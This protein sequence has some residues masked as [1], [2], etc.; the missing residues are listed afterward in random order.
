VK[1][2]ASWIRELGGLPADLSTETIARGIADVGFEIA[3]IDGDVIDFEITANRPDC[4]SVRGLAREGA[5]KFRGSGVPGFRGSEVPEF[6]SSGVPEFRGAEV[7]VEIASPLC[8]RFA[9]AMADVTVGPSPQWLVDRLTACGVRSINNIVDV[10][11]YVMLEMGQPMH[12]Y[13]AAKVAGNRL[14]ARLAAK[15][16][17][18]TTL[19]GVKRTLDASMLVIADDSGAV[20]VAGVMGG[21]ASEVSPA[22]TRIA[23]E[24]AYFQPAAVRAT[25]K[26]L[27]LKTEASTRFERGADVNGG[28]EAIAMALDLLERIGAGRRASAITDVYPAPHTP[29]TV[30]LRPAK[31]ARLLGDAVPAADVEHIL[32]S[33]GFALAPATDGWTVT[34]PS[35][36]VDVA[37]EADL[38]EEVG[39]HWGV[40]RVPAT[41]PALQAPPRVSDAGVLRSRRLRRLLCG[42][43]LQ[44]AVTFTFMERAA[45][46]PFVAAGTTLVEIANPLSEKFAVLRPAIVPGL[47]D[48]L[49]YNRRRGMDDVRLFEAGAIFSA[50]GES[51]QVGWV[52]SGSRDAH[53][54][55]GDTPVDVFDALGVATVVADA[56]GVTL[57]SSPADAPGYVA[58]RTAQLALD[59]RVVGMVGQVDARVAEARGLPQGA[60]VVAGH[61]DLAAFSGD[62]TTIAKVA[63]V[64][65][66]P[67]VV[68][69]IALLV[70]DSLPAAAL[71]ATIRQQPIPWLRSVVEF[72]RY[73]G[74]NIPAGKVSLAFRLTFQDDGRTLTDAEVDDAF[75]R[76]VDAVVAAHEAEVRGR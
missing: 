37:R 29:R 47:L 26:R 58:G 25:S 16:E 52:L 62:G 75:T 70:A 56:W 76:I 72:D 59:G 49:I 28:P 35:W 34:V 74:R 23:L 7:Q 54:S 44:E 31:L 53:W 19:D 71:R 21:A 45:A 46:E 66:F 20:G 18:L 24:A 27:G 36:R 42:A 1:A 51:Q 39:R 67:A 33:L 41:F 60:T 9:L 40:N 15:G 48:A 55:L 64:P 12:A 3:S 8:G 69:D 65:R 4:L 63:A 32:S 14:V 5:T 50:A 57:T 68:R 13:D 43:G 2:P 22:T 38:I 30:A 61:L 11:N 73:Q 6:R 10:T 17:T